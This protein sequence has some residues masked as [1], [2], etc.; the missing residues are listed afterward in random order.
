MAAT[1]TYYSFKARRDEMG[2]ET[3]PSAKELYEPNNYVFFKSLS[4]K[5]RLE[6]IQKHIDP[7]SAFRM[8]LTA[9]PNCVVK[10]KDS[11]YIKVITDPKT[12][13]KHDI[14][15]VLRGDFS[16]LFFDID[17]HTLLDPDE[18]VEKAFKMVGQIVQI[19]SNTPN[20]SQYIYAV[21]ETNKQD[22]A[23]W[24]MIRNIISQAELYDEGEKKNTILFYNP[25]TT[26]ELSSHIYINKFYFSRED[27]YDL[28]QILNSKVKREDSSLPN[29]IDTCVYVKNQRVFR[30]PLSGKL[31][32]NRKPS[33]YVSPE[34]YAFAK[35]N[36]FK[37]VAT[38]TEEDTTLISGLSK[39][40]TTLKTLINSCVRVYKIPKQITKAAIDTKICSM[41]REEG[42]KIMRKTKIGKQESEAAPKTIDRPYSTHA[43]WY[44]QL[45]KKVAIH[46]LINKNIS[47]EALFEKFSK[48]EYQYFSI[49][50]NK[51]LYQPSSV[52]SAILSARKQKLSYKDMIY[53]FDTV[54]EQIIPQSFQVFRDKVRDQSLTVIEVCIEIYRT[55][56]FFRGSSEMKNSAN[57]VVYKNEDDEYLLMPIPEFKKFLHD[58]P[59]LF[60]LKLPNVDDNGTIM[61]VLKPT[62][63]TFCIDKFQQFQRYY[64]SFDFFSLNPK[65]FHFYKQP[66]TPS[67]IVDINDERLE[68]VNEVINTWAA[69][70]DDEVSQEKKDYILDYFAYML[71]HPE[72]RNFHALIVSSLPGIGKNTITNMLCKYIG[73]NNTLSN[74]DIDAHILNTFN[75]TI[76]MKKFIVV[77]ELNCEDRNTDA[78]KSLITEDEIIINKKNAAQRKEQNIANYIFFT[79]HADVSIITSIHDRRFTFIRSNGKP[80]TKEVCDKIY[81]GPGDFN[82]KEDVYQAFINHLLSRDLSNYNPSKP[83]NF[84][85]QQLQENRDTKKHP[86]Y[87]IIKLLVKTVFKDQHFIPCH[88]IQQYARANVDDPE[89]ECC[90]EMAKYGEFEEYSDAVETFRKTDREMKIYKKTIVEILSKHN[91]CGFEWKRCKK[92]EYKDMYGIAY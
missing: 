67:E 71:Q 66:I 30:H 27:L 70:D 25:Y 14:A 83:K 21:V 29:C 63:L 47:D 44:H 74:A 32:Q 17:C 45:I 87:R 81:A 57:Y 48:E 23:T 64:N 18:E 41:V 11:E 88:I 33:P 39:E 50:N 40:F 3:S 15:E 2:I 86:L 20:Y 42:E 37:F 22:D 10:S 68:G 46:L 34:D 16:R 24:A 60:Q 28:F 8:A 62:E 69:D 43:E 92:G 91:E 75:S 65:N 78:L 80:I 59:I 1:N 13:Q 89:D 51:K 31:E 52:K 5:K 54:D 6:A 84:D 56:V 38:K 19:I 90:I 79:N 85:K 53:N 36:F 72:T 49:S 61:D 26:K 76:D 77:N 55:F 35:H 9:D 73:L 4:A 58:R 82:F 7:P 12:L